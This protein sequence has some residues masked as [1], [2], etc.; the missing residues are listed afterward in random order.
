M[1]RK[2]HR[3]EVVAE[4]GRLTMTIRKERGDSLESQE[5]ISK[6]NTV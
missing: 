3:D 1:V 2:Q 5:L 4:I 6:K